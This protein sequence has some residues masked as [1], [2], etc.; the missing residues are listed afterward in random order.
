MRVLTTEGVQ[1]E[2]HLPFA[3]LH[4]LLRPILA[5]VEALPPPQRDAIRSAFGMSIAAAPELFLIALH[6]HPHQRPATP[7][8]RSTSTD[9][10]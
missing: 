4:Q 10:S 9:A 3:G 2:A 1:S 5:G 6:A 8:A 7:T